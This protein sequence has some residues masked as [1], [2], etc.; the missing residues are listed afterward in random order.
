MTRTELYNLAGRHRSSEKIS[1]ALET[2]QALGLAK[3]ETAPTEGRNKE[4]WILNQK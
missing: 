3:K 2:L 4:I 1:T